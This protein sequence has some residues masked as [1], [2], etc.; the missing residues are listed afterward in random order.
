MSDGEVTSWAFPFP[1]DE[2]EDAAVILE[3]LDKVLDALTP[4]ARNGTSRVRVGGKRRDRKRL[5][6]N[7]LCINGVKNCMDPQCGKRLVR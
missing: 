7:T 2:N 4:H 5:K 3:G 1:I 6:K